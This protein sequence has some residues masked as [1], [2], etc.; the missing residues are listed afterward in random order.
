ME[1]VRVK[2]KLTQEG[3]NL[4][5]LP[6]KILQPLRV[7][8]DALLVQPVGNMQATG[9]RIGHVD[10][11]VAIKLYRNLLN[12]ACENDVDLLVTPEYCL[13]WQLVGEI[14]ETALKPKHNSLWALG[15]ESIT[16]GDL[17][18]LKAEWEQHDIKVLYET[19]PPQNRDYLCPLVYIFWVN[20]TGNETHLC[21]LIQFKS[22]PCKDNIEVDHLYLGN[23]VYIFG[24]GEN[25][26]NF[27]SLICAD[28]FELTPKQII[29]NHK[30]SLIL[31][32]Q[33]NEKPWH[34]TFTQYR[35]KLFSVGSNNPVELMCL[36]WAMGVDFQIK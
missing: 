30:D 29:D 15:C 32:I 36:N 33:L 14:V 1:F 19:P 13:P 25:E 31:H 34:P 21:I 2:E 17:D 3:N 5:I 11:D 16:L 24:N 12:K 22:E 4:T 26:L 9:L 23:D 10:Q 35:Q 28:V 7:P 18:T 20:N 6:L 8:Y 27:F